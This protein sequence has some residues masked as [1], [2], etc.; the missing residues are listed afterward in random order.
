MNQRF[1]TR[2][3]LYVAM[4]A[5]ASYLV[6]M[7]SPK[8]KQTSIPPTH[9]PVQVSYDKTSSII[10]EA[11]TY[12][13]SLGFRTDFA[14]LIDLASHSGNIRLFGFNLDTKET[15]I[16]GLVAHGHCKSTD[17]RYAQF[18]N[19]ISSNCSSLGR[20]KIG[21]KYEGK[22][23]TSYK[24]NGLDSTN[25]NALNRYIVL[26]SHACVPLKS[27]DDDICLSEGCPTVNPA[28]FAELSAYMDQSD[29]PILLWIYN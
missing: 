6:Y 13:D 24:L 26:H 12:C 14:V 21:Q 20:Y 18:S 22:F 27:Q 4:L 23:G 17:N 15:L 5:M 2:I 3:L 25:S 16:K 7:L 8:A 19:A 28:I 29:Q 11:L 10:N 1:A 9:I